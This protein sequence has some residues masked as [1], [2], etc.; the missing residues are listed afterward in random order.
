[1]MTDVLLLVCSWQSCLMSERLMSLD[2]ELYTW[3]ARK[4]LIDIRYIQFSRLLLYYTEDVGV[5][6]LVTHMCSLACLPH[7]VDVLWLFDTWFLDA[8]SVAPTHAIHL[9]VA[10][11]ALPASTSAEALTDWR[12]QRPAGIPST[13]GYLWLNGAKPV[14]RPLVNN[15][16]SSGFTCAAA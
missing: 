3:V 10:C 8:K 4:K 6:T 11:A 12:C 15:P 7:S 2:R 5:Q 16:R 9:T 14:S 13:A 1:M